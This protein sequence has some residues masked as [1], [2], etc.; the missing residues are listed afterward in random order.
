MHPGNLISKE[1]S[2]FS[3]YYDA[4][5]RALELRD[6]GSSSV[7]WSMAQKGNIFARVGNGEM[8]LHHMNL[9]L[10]RGLGNNLLDIYVHPG[11]GDIFQVEANMGY[12]AGVAEMLIQSHQGY[13]QPLPALPE[14]W[15]DGSYTGLVARGNFETDAVWADGSLTDFTIRSGSGGECVVRYPNISKATLTGA[16]FTVVDANTV[17]FNT[18]KDG[19]YTF[20]NILAY[21]PV[22][23]I[24][25]ASPSGVTLL[26]QAGQTIQLTAEVAPVDASDLGVTWKATKLNGTPTQSVVIDQNGLLTAM[27]TLARETVKVT[28][29]AKDGS[30]TKGE[31]LIMVVT[32]RTA[33]ESKN[34]VLS[35]PVTMTGAEIYGRPDLKLEHVNDGNLST[36]MAI[37]GDGQTNADIVF[38]FELDGAKVIDRVDLYEYL[39]RNWGT[40]GRIDKLTVEI[41]E[42]DN[43]K[44][45]AAKETPDDWGGDGISRLPIPPPKTGGAVA[46]ASLQL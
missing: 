31:I 45:V 11:W 1:N 44:L 36:R 32:D 37:A 12:T 30:A 42:G 24:T 27:E 43:W 10:T 17:K 33:G 8:A 25:V 35:Q 28:A 20:I 26:E 29:V 23:E 13:I 2:S 19:E 41:P 46:A 6:D 40:N 4:A 7:G 5:V 38:E 14:E 39:D 21:K 16:D 18:V 15:A 22:R 3:E 34:V 9:L